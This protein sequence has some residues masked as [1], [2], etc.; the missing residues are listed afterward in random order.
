MQFNLQNGRI[1]T[2]LFLIVKQTQIIMQTWQFL[3]VITIL[4]TILESQIKYNHLSSIIKIFRSLQLILLFSTIISFQNRHIYVG[5]IVKIPNFVTACY[6]SYANKCVLL[7]QE[8]YLFIYENKLI[9][10]PF[11]T[12][13][14]I[15][16]K[17]MS[18]LFDTVHTIFQ[19]M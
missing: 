16:V 10:D 19:S 12:T 15:I 2:I 3:L 7:K 14:I 6:K 13:V 1:V 17:R 11:P 9:V 5:Q 18:K 4:L 8:Y